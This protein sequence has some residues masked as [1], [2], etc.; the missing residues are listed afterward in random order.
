MCYTSFE[1]RLS[2]VP[3]TQQKIDFTRTIYKTY[4]ALSDSWGKEE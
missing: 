3:D 2:A 1:L 4:Y